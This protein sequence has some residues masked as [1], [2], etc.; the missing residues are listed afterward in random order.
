MGI[1]KEV[2]IGDCRLLLGDNREILPL[3]NDIGT[4][5]T[6]PPYGIK[7]DSTMAKKSGKQYGN[8]AAPKNVYLAT[9]WDGEP[10]SKEFGELLQRLGKYVI[11]WGGNYFELPPTSCWL[12]WDKENGSN[13]F[14]DCELAWTNLKQAVRLKR[15]MWNG[16]LRKGGEERCGHP[17][18]KPR[19]I[20]Q[21]LVRS[22]SYPGSTVLDFFAGSGVTARVSI[23]EGRNSISCDFD[24]VFLKYLAKQV[25]FLDENDMLK[26]HPDFE[27]VDKISAVLEDARSLKKR[28]AAD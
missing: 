4:I 27:F 3:L 28:H 1:K 17:T 9:D 25:S 10:M 18:Q 21:R 12:I 7:A 14:A 2:I 15:H 6:D 8:A 22:L 24:R 19:D 23:E 13:N 26:S 16:M 20:I 5:L 11:I